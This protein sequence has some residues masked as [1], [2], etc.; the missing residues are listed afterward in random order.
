MKGWVFCLQSFCVTHFLIIC[1]LDNSTDF[2]MSD[3]KW[4]S[5]LESSGWLDII[6]SGYIKKINPKLCDLLVLDYEII[7]KMYL[8]SSTDSVSKKQ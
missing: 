8:M 2:W 6:R 7:N 1:L 4:F 3:M 5:S